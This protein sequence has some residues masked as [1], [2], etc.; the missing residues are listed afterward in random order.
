ML[1][2]KRCHHFPCIYKQRDKSHQCSMAQGLQPPFNLSRR[3]PAFLLGE[4]FVA[5]VCK[6]R[7]F[8][9]SANQSL[10]PLAGDPQEEEPKS[11][12]TCE[13]GHLR[14]FPLSPENRNQR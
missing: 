2:G 3:L 9:A 13:N 4:G 1:P 14:N 5:L 6:L 8:K 10:L 7:K 12:G 11:H